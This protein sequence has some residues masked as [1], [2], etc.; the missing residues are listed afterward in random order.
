MS[1]WIVVKPCGPHQRAM[2][3]GCVHALNTSRRGASMTRVTTSSRSA[4]LMFASTALLLA[5]QFLQVALEAVEALFPEDAVVLQPVGRT[6]E[7]A[8]FQPAWAPLCLTAAGDQAGV[9]QHLEV[10]GDRGEAHVERFG[11]FGDRG[12]AGG[13]PCQDRPARRVRE[14]RECATEAIRRHAV[15]NLMV[16]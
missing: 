9:L 10:L 6:L 13:Q 8:R 15:V 7:R 16:K 11:Q 2:C 5:L 4:V 12:L 14:G 1:Q 3:S